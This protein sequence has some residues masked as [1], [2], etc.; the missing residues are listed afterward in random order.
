M[1]KRALLLALLALA[2]DWNPA[3][4]FEGF[5]ADRPF[6]STTSQTLEQGIYQLEQGAR[7]DS[8]AASAVTFPS[9]HRLGLGSD[10][11]LMLESPLVTISSGQARMADLS[12]GAKWRF[13]EGD[14][15]LPAMGLLARAAI[16]ESG[17]V[18]PRLTWAVEAALPGAL[19]LETNLGTSWEEDATAWL[20][21]SAALAWHLTDRLNLCAEVA[22][23]GSTAAATPRVGV[24]GGLAWL[25]EP[26]TQLDMLLYKGMTP[27]AADWSASIG[28][29]RRWGS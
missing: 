6:I 11:E 29:S 28:L 5:E 2:G 3:L 12:I 16:A 27:Q 19:M 10:V 25:L 4:A 8:G 7:F 17:Q 22:G 24:D 1:F 21:Y 23:E 18:L 14:E 26:S 15:G 9:V 20:H 13:V